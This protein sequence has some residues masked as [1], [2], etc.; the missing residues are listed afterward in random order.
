[1]KALTSKQEALCDMVL[2]LTTTLNEALPT[3]SSVS[4]DANEEAAVNTTKLT[5]AL[6]SVSSNVNKK[7]VVDMVGGMYMGMMITLFIV[8]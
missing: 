1:M 3:S 8:K 6:Q 4:A 7:D 5:E 2:R